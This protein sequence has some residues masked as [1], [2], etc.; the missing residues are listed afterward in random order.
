[1]QFVGI[2]PG[3]NGAV[4][5][6]DG[7]RRCIEVHDTPLGRD[8]DY[9]GPAMADLIRRAATTEQTV[10]IIEAVHSMPH[11]GKASAFTFGVGLGRWLGICDALGIKVNPVSP[12]TWKRTMLAGIANDK[13]AEAL[14]LERRF[15]GHKLDLRGPRGGL[16]DGRVDAIFLAEFGRLTWKTAGVACRSGR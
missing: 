12:R 7:E 15:Q 3:L 1:M 2:D 4:A 11:D 8:R 16:R 9:D 13:E 6:V 10:I 5:I 14:A